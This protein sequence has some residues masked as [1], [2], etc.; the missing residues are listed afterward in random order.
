[1]A[2]VFVKEYNGETRNAQLYKW[3]NGLCYQ[4]RMTEGA[5]TT[6]REFN[7][8]Q[9]AEEFAREWIKEKNEPKVSKKIKNNE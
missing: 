7:T 3:A 2:I 6:E 4:V 8:E 9:D 5:N 1:M